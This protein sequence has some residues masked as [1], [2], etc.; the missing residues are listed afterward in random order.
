MWDVVML[1]DLY[2]AGMGPGHLPDAGGVNDQA[3]WLMEAFK[4]MDAAER[5]LKKGMGDG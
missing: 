2:R 5:N 4:I 1:W 3:C